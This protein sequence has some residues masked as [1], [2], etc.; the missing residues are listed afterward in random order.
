[1]S[2]D[3]SG[4]T[5]RSFVQTPVSLFRFSA[6]TFNAHKIHYNKDWCQKVEGHRDLVVHGPLNL[7]N[8]VD[9]WRD[10]TGLEYPKKVTYRATNPLYCGEK[11]TI[12]A[13]AEVENAT[14]MTILDSYGVVSMTGQIERFT[15]L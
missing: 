3:V 10:I 11:Y 4:K 6:L 7:I 12:I 13:D 1:M 14:K 15:T 2:D 9:F 5:L 8:M